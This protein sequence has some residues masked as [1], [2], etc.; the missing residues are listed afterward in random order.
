MKKI[1]KVIKVFLVLLFMLAPGAL[2]AWWVWAKASVLISVMAI[3]GVELS[4]LL[5]WGFIVALAATY[6]QQKAEASTPS[7][8]S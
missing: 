5:F 4:W 2:F 6:K 3:V 7:D 8:K 1:F